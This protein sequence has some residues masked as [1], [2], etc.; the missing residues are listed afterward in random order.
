VEGGSERDFL[1]QGDAMVARRAL[2]RGFRLRLELKDLSEGAGLW[3]E[4]GLRGVRWRRRGVAGAEILADG[5]PVA[6]SDEQGIAQLELPAEPGRIE[7]RLP[8]WRV[9]ESS[10]YRDGVVTCRATA[11]LP[12]VRE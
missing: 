6:T 8:G 5:A 2:H 7:V 3:R 11:V 1:L 10:C 12:M 9:L 4:T